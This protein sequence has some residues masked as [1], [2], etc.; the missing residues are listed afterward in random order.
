M[1]LKTSTFSYEHIV[2]L[3]YYPIILISY[4]LITLRS[5]KRHITPIMILWGIVPVGLLRLGGVGVF[6]KF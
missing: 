4:Y 5:T 6:E 1:L 3:S 2:L